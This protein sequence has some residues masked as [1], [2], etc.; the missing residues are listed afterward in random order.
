MTGSET[1][2]QRAIQ[3]FRDHFTSLP[4]EKVSFPRGVS[5]V[6]KWKDRAAIYKKGT[7]IPRMVTR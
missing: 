1:N 3:Q 5:D 7:P 4:P 6:I 2:T